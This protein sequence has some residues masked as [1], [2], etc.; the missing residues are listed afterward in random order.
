MPQPFDSDAQGELESLTE[1]ISSGLE[2]EQIL[3]LIAQRTCQV[4][5]VAEAHIFLKQGPELIRKASHQALQE[6][7]LRSSL[8]AGEGIEG[9]VLRRGRAI[10]LEDAQADRRFR[11]LAEAAPR[12]ANR[13]GDMKPKIAAVPIW[14]GRQVTGI[15]SIIDFGVPGSPASTASASAA[16][17]IIGLLPLLSVLADLI[18]LALENTRI[19]AR[20]ERRSKLIR[21]LHYMASNLPDQMLKEVAQAMEE[22]IGEVMGVQ[23]VEILLY[24][25]ET[26]ELVAL[27]TNDAGLGRAQQE[28]GLDHLPLGKAGMLADVFRTGQPFLSN[29]LEQ[30][31]GFPAALKEKLGLKAALVVPL[32]VEQQ[33]RGLISVMSTRPDVFFEEDLAFLLLISTRVSHMVHHQEL[34]RE[35]AQAEA[36]RLDRAE[37]EN[38]LFVVAHDLKNAL[39]TIRGNAQL[40]LRRAAKGEAHN[41]EQALRLIATRSGQAIQ[42]VNDMV[43]VNQMEIGLFRLFMEPVELVEFLQEEIATVNETSDEQHRITFQSGLKEVTVE[44]DQT[45]IIQ[46]LTNLLNNAIRYSPKGGTIEVILSKAPSEADSTVLDNQSAEQG[47]LPQA[48]MVTINDEGIGLAPEERE[49]IFERS[50]RGRGASFAPGSGLGLY[51]SREIIERHGGR[52]WAEPRERQGSSFRFTLPISRSNLN[53]PA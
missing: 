11:P 8:A 48:V 47:Q 37:R 26:D 50:F 24:N 21:L 42:L 27:G 13:H 34:S 2:P 35:L 3:A 45:R 23:K 25:E 41:N 4:L 14:A 9:W 33:R 12:K 6:T 5:N 43:D 44:A 17:P 51:I 46:V 38:F 18:S 28:L 32:E 20:E 30:E 7:S 29:D 31:P 16:A 36:E 49:R 1:A 19:L 52:L 39:T 10:A 15:L 40:A 22:R 53:A